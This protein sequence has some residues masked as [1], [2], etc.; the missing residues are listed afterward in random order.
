VTDPL[1][2][3]PTHGRDAVVRVP[4]AREHHLRHVDVDIPRDAIVALTGS[5]PECH[6][7][8]TVHRLGEESRVP[9]RR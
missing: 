2:E 6:G 1:G 7:L 5:R 4:G 9:D 8:S 3:P